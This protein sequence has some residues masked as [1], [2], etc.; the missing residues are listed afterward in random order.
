MKRFLG[1]ICLL[2]ISFLLFAGEVW[3]QPYDYQLRKFVYDFKTINSGN[4]RYHVYSYYKNSGDNLDL[5][6]KVYNQNDDLIQDE[7]LIADSVNDIINIQGDQAGNLFVSWVK[8]SNFSS[9]FHLKKINLST[10]QNWSFDYVCDTNVPSTKIK[11]FL[12]ANGQSGIFMGGEENLFVLLNENGSIN[13]TFDYQ[14]YFGIPNFVCLNSFYKNGNYYIITDVIEET[15]MTVLSANGTLLETLILDDY[16]TEYYTKV[17]ETS[18]DFIFCISDYEGQTV[19]HRID[20]S[21]SIRQIKEIDFNSISMGGMN[22]FQITKSDND[23]FFF[24]WIN[25]D[26]G[27]VSLKTAYMDTTLTINEA[28]T[29]T[30]LNYD[31]LLSFQTFSLS[32][33]SLGLII[34][35]NNQRYL[36]IVNPQGDLFF[37]S[38]AMIFLSYEFSSL[39]LSDHNSQLLLTWKSNSQQKVFINKINQNGFM[40]TEPIELVN[41][42]GNSI[43]SN[44][45]AETT[46]GFYLF[47]VER[48]YSRYQIKYLFVNL[49]Y[50][51][52][53]D[54]ILDEFY[55]SNP[56]MFPVINY[57]Q[58]I[59]LFVFRSNE[60]PLVYRFD[61]YGNMLEND[62][63]VLTDIVINNYYQM[64]SKNSQNGFYLYY[65]D[66]TNWKFYRFEN[67]LPVGT[68]PNELSLNGGYINGKKDDYLFCS[69]GIYKLNEDG[70]CSQ[71]YAQNIYFRNIYRSFKNGYLM[72]IHNEN[73]ERRFLYFNKADYSVT[74]LC[75][76]DVFDQFSISKDYLYALV[77]NE[78]SGERYL[79]KY[80]MENNEFVPQWEPDIVFSFDCY[81][82]SFKNKPYVVKR[83]DTIY[84]NLY[85]FYQDGTPLYDDDGLLVHFMYYH[86]MEEDNEISGMRYY[87]KQLENEIVFLTSASG[88]YSLSVFISDH[89]P[90][91]N[92]DLIEIPHSEVSIYPNPFNP[93]T[94]IS[95]YAENDQETEVCIY[96]IKGQ[97]VKT[98]FNGKCRSGQQKMIWN[99]TND[100]GDK[101]GSGVYFC[102]IKNDKQT[103]IQKMM[104]VK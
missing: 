71:V 69:N 102:R 63:I 32:N 104:L 86:Y 68:N 85:S 21:G 55:F 54:V 6:Y 89:D 30:I 87:M 70:N 59:S 33:G 28:N 62:P 103:K 52:T 65:R 2:M 34:S 25:N 14:L 80:V 1:I 56:N 74:E 96:N 61:P 3:D 37:Q 78:N 11:H 100:S 35:D 26:E 40:N 46:G 7:I 19:L 88:A 20:V 75:Y 72:Q 16:Y 73:Y 91:P 95:F 18:E 92:A 38:T 41:N 83:Y 93:S 47:R 94:T 67:N 79:Q 48:Y 44:S 97:K 24:T 84:S 49:Q 90:A 8:I 22:N 42:N 36:Q 50:E 45:V 77:R 10:Q 13:W 82:F 17:I 23:H 57:D 53:T 43:L 76:P 101:T 15:R 66:T 98:L 64:F 4:L 12:Y 27:Q 81:L 5:C 60:H 9:V 58:S 99:G 39:Q 29:Y 31:N 51:I